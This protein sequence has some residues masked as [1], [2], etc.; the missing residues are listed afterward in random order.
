MHD[1]PGNKASALGLGLLATSVNINTIRTKCQHQH[2]LA[3]HWPLAEIFALACWTAACEILAFYS[4]LAGGLE[5]VRPQS[6][7]GLLRAS[8]CALRRLPCLPD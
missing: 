4:Q 2:Q 6:L 8:T 3:L 5:H 1:G 7:R